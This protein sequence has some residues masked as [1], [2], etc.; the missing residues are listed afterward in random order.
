MLLGRY[1]RSQLDLIR[2]NLEQQVQT[3]Q[4]CQKANRGGR[5]GKSFITG[6][7]IFANFV[8]GQ[9]WL[10]GTIIRSCGPRSFLIELADGREVRRYTFVKDYHIR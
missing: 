6:S 1:P 2:L 10:S 7:P 9:K 4:I 3:K 8:S 5:T